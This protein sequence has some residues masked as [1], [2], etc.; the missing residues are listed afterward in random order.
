[1]AIFDF[2]HFRTI[3]PLWGNVLM[4]GICAI[5]CMPY[6]QMAYASENSRCVTCGIIDRHA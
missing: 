3:N 2:Y 6:G 4:A 1:M 5:G